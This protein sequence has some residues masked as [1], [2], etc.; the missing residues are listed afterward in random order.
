MSDE[1]EEPGMYLRSLRLKNFRS[2]YDMEVEFQPGI[3]LLVGEN[4]SGK[5]NVIEALRLAT[6]PL[7]RRATRYF[8]ESDL[9]HGQKSQE[10]ELH[11]SY[12][13]LTKT[14]RAHYI[15][16][17]DVDTNQAIY[18][19]KYA[20]D[21]KRRHNVRST[22][23]AGP[24]GGTDA[25]PEKREQIAHVYLAP[26]RDAKRE[27]D[28]SDGNRL[29]RIIQHL[30]TKEEREEFVDTANESFKELKK[31]GVLTTTTGEIQGHLGELTNSVRGQ[32]VEVTFADYELN[33]LARSLRVKMAEHGIEPA[34]L[35][36]SGLGY[37]N[38]LFIATVILELRKAQD[39]ELTLFLVE[40]PEAHLHPQLQAVLL[41]YLRE[42][43]EASPN[44]DTQGPAGRIQVIATTHS[45]SLASS[46]GIENVVAL[47]TRIEKETI[48]DGED[49]KEV[50]RRK[51]N[52]LP[53]AKIKLD[54][55]AR[56]KINQYLDATRVGLLFA[57]RV[58]LVEGVAEAVLLPVIARHCVFGDD[59]D[60]VQVKQRR[61]FHGV[62]IVN[63]GS[64]DFAPY[65][66]L[67]LSEVNGCRLLDQLTVVTDRDPDVP[68]EKKSEET[69]GEETAQE[70]A[71]AEVDD[72]QED[73]GD[74]D[75]AE[76]DGD[77]D[78]TVVNNRK[79]RL[80][81]H[82]EAIG[83]EDYLVVAEAP[84]TLEAD[85]LTPEGNEPVLKKA[86]LS[87]HPKSQKHWREIM[88]NEKTP[89]WG[90]YLKLRK[91]KKFMSKGQFAHDVAL[92][93]EDKE[94]FKAPDY[95]AEAIR[96]V[97]EDGTDG[98]AK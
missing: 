70:E 80:M 87:Q 92:S 93:I 11:A 85:L 45:P 94:A 3:T 64:V 62:T 25:E 12:D 58:I 1:N 90:F 2:C 89:T 71:E 14:Q 81:E 54:D 13:G 29:L 88:A 79:D 47:R 26:L 46:V 33:R 17:L 24:V 8:D 95:L 68:K 59:D 34:D 40:E 69:E 78:E 42:Q 22:F 97:L 73:E 65:I 36:E 41:D 51:T 72:V 19:A 49:T 21:A 74:G 75:E 18:S 61:A 32:S 16:A 63:V 10:A 43:S 96:G 48:Q 28:S 9:S 98:G 91:N 6:A 84:H 86:Y 67:L 50:A 44:D 55:S 37:A 56:R 77:D 20:I 23:T 57:R 7:N 53:L 60:P 30:T 83:A 66:T 31:H 76:N 35:T 38:L 4:N 39:A 52:A 82:A 15:A 5:S 27:L